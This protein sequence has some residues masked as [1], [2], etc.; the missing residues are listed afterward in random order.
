[1]SAPE[2]IGVD[3]AAQQVAWREE[4]EVVRAGVPG[5]FAA[6]YDPG[7]DSL[8]VL[9]RNGGGAV[10]ILSR[11]GERL[12]TVEAP[13]GYVVSHFADGAATTIVCQGE[14]P[15]GAWWDWHFAVDPQCGEMRKTGPA[16]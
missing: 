4:G 2:A 8:I 3:A 6:R 10:A 7:S 16:Y 14:A 1:V 5:A 11:N 9:T 12:A 13:P 15:D